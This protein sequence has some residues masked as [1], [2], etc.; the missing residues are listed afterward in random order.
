MF[1][2]KLKRVCGRE[3]LRDDVSVSRKQDRSIECHA[4]V[5]QTSFHGRSGDEL[6][7]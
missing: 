6:L 4:G 2:I 1:P 7:P 5:V 3:R